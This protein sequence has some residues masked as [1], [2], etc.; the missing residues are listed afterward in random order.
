M[1]RVAW[2]GGQVCI[3]WH[4]GEDGY[5]SCGIVGRAIMNSVA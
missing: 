2:A 4:S 1:C 5:V 3:V